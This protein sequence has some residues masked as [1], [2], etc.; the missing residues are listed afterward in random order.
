MAAWNPETNGTDHGNPEGKSD[1]KSI[2][3]RYLASEAKQ[4]LP[5]EARAQRWG[6]GT[7]QR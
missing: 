5:D 2:N 1:L 6:N 4:D 7:W 3:I